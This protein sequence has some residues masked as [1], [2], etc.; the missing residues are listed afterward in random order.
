MF[1]TFFERIF[2]KDRQGGGCHRQTGGE[3]TGILLRNNRAAG[4]AQ[5]RV[6][7]LQRPAMVSNQVLYQG[8]ADELRGILSGH[9]HRVPHW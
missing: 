3:G 4:S 7:V 5:H 9:A 1:D 6:A 8:V 2:Q